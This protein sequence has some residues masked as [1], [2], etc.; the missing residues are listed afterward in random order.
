MVFETDLV[1]SVF[2]DFAEYLYGKNM[3]EQQDWQPG[4]YHLASLNFGGLMDASS[5]Q[6]PPYPAAD[7]TSETSLQDIFFNDPSF[8]VKRQT[9]WLEFASHGCDYCF[10]MI[11]Y[12]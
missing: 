10:W 5:F 4:Q 8:G 1:T 7:M 11:H 9:G 2:H 6:V 3:Q 12:R